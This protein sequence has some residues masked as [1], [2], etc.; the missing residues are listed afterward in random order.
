MRRGLARPLAL[1]VIRSGD[2]ILV[3][4]VPDRVRGVLGYRPLGG[5][6]EFGKR[7]EAAIV[8]EI[9]EEIEAELVDVRY[10]E[11]LENIFEYLGRPGHELVRVYEGRLADEALYE[12]ETIVAREENG[13]RLRCVWKPIAD[14][15]RGDPLYPDGLLELLRRR[16]P[17]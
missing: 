3:F 14:F 17:R 7:G 1:A 6:I 2:R 12:R 13:S 5:T 16:A 8:R 11:T 9:R 15:E 4:D 10:V